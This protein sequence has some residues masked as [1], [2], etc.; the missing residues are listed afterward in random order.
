MHQIEKTSK[1][2]ASVIDSDADEAMVPTGCC[3]CRS[4]ASEKFEFVELS[5]AF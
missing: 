2:M 5:Y 1:M 4:S 3:C